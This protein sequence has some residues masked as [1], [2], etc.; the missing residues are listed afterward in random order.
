MEMVGHLIVSVDFLI[1]LFFV[2][3]VVAARRQLLLIRALTPHTCP[4][5][6]RVHACAGVPRLLAVFRLRRSS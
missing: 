3:V 4:G 2:V 5:T 6:F 1:G